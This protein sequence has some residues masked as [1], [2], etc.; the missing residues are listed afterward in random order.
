MSKIIPSE[1]LL[2]AYA[3]GVFPMAHDGEIQWFSPELRGLIPLDDRFHISHGLRK[4]L[5]R[6]PFE[7]RWNT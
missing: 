7:I 3:Q 6:E 1:V 5:K 2:E 4:A